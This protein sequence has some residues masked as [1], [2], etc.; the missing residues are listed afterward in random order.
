VLYSHLV[1]IS[2]ELEGGGR[3]AGRVCDR[4][5]RLADNCPLIVRQ[6]SE[7]LLTANTF[8]LLKHFRPELWLQP[9][10]RKAY[11]GHVASEA[12][13]RPDVAFWQ[14]VDPPPMRFGSEGRTEVDVHILFGH[15]VLYIEAKYGAPLSPSTTADRATS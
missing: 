8:G 11:G 12:V 5:Y 14:H 2:L 15:S 4:S 1:S 3:K 6:N 10:L 7:D 9:I 13:Q